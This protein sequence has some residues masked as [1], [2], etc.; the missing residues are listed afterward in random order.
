MI[1][2]IIPEEKIQQVARLIDRYEQ[3]AIVCHVA[4]DGDAIGSSLALWHFMNELGKTATVIVPDVLPDNLKFLKGAKDILVWERYSEFAGEIIARAELIFCLDFNA[5]KRIDKMSEAVAAAKARKV[6]I[7]HHLEP[8]SFCDVVISHPE[9]SSTSELVFRLICRLG[10]FDLLTVPCGEA[11][12]V[13]MMTD[14]GNFTYNSNKPEIYF[15]IGELVKKGVDKDA[16]YA[17]IYNRNTVDK[18]RLNGYAVHEKMEVFP[19]YQAAL[20]TLSRPEL[21]RFHY[22]KGDTEGL[23]NVPLSIE[24]VVFSGF[25]REETHLIKISFRSKGDFPAN[26][27]AAEYFNGGGH[28]NAAGGEFYGTLEEARTRFIEM[29]PAF[30]SYLKKQKNKE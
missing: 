8:E 18:V 3:V 26:R 9:I 6:M 21:N 25:F 16:L 27:A 12:Y 30:K 15:I 11:I 22:R 7:D 20:I 17:R 10:M 28:L 1:T 29:L 23:V 4:P 2:K 24:N 5:L 19:E 13:G 14:T